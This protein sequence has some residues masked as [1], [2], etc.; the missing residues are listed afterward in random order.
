MP[1][2]YL[3]DQGQKP[4]ACIDQLTYIEWIEFVFNHP[5]PRNRQER[6]YSLAD[7]EK[8]YFKNSEVFLKHLTRLMREPDFLLGR[9]STEQIK[10]GFWCFITAFELSDLLEDKDLDFEIRHQC[11]DSIESLYH[12]LF[13]RS[14]FEKIA[15]LFWDSLTYTFTDRQALSDDLDQMNIH[16]AMFHCLTRILGH[17]ER[18][19]FISAARGL[20][21]LRHIQGAR[22]IHEALRH[23]ASVN[24][25]DRTYALACTRCEAD[26]LPR[27][28]LE[29]SVS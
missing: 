9:Y 11:I 1:F 8:F 7:A 24:E 13:C 17:R 25:E 15:F 16:N 18:I 14:G 4:E 3:F 29:A 21:H 22:A 10:Q 20:S 19:N 6:W 27:P 12:L 23:R 5:T 26:L 2:R 28:K